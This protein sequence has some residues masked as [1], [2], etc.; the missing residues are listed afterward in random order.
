MGMPL[1]TISHGPEISGMFY[2][3]TRDTIKINACHS[4][5]IHF[6]LKHYIRFSNV[7]AN[8]NFQVLSY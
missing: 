4:S 3:R 1:G 5:T 8:E 6:F 2:N 7:T